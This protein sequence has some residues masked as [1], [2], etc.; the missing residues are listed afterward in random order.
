M[1][2]VRDLATEQRLAECSFDLHRGEIL[3]VAGLQGMGQSELFNALFGVGPTT[4]GSI[5][6]E[7]QPVLLAPPAKPSTPASGSFP[8]IARRRGCFWS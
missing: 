8:R 4:S 3:G 6:L 7:G 1:L 2:S 5:E